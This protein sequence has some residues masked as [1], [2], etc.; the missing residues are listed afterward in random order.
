AG[1]VPL[2]RAIV[3]TKRDYVRGLM[4]GIDE[5][6]VAELTL[7]GLPM[8]SV[9]FTAGRIPRPAAPAPVTPTLGTSPGLSFANL[10]P[11]YTLAGHDR[12]LNLV[13][14]GT[15]TATFF[16]AVTGGAAPDTFTTPGQPIVPRV[17]N[18]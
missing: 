4:N 1:P 10:S 6:S 11:T 2:G 8:T 16:D 12:L 7:Y 17:V 14:G 9:N 5:K 13:G 15:T 18:N 3:E